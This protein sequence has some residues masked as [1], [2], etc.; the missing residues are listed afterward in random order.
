METAVFERKA[1][2]LPFEALHKVSDYLDDNKTGLLI[3]NS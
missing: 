1:K 3:P 2:Q